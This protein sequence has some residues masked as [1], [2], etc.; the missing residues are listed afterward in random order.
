MFD[1]S[2]QVEGA[3]PERAAAAPLLR[4]RL[5]ISERPALGVPPTPIQAVALNCQL[6]IEPARRRYDAR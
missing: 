4:F 5:G 3:E 2:F 1:L 6:R